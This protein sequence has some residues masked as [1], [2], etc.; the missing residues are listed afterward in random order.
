MEVNGLLLVSLTMTVGAADAPER[1]YLWVVDEGTGL[2]I[3]GATVGT[4]PGKDCVGQPTNE[5]AAWTA[6]YVTGPAGRAESQTFSSWFSCRVTLNGK[7]LY[8]VSVGGL[9]A[10]PGVARS[11]FP[12]SA[13]LRFPDGSIDARQNR[14]RFTLL[15]T[16]R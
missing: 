4:G 13:R 12:F 6:H 11:G 8:V 3:P 7:Q 1:G 10:R 2:G 15:G 5:N 14:G 9:Q 16:Y